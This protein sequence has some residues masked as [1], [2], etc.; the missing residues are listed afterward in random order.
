MPQ[1]TLTLTLRLYDP[2]EKKDSAKSTS[3]A[4][5]QVDRADLQMDQG[6]FIEKYLRPNL[7][8]LKQL[9]LTSL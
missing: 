5:V 6:Y 8:Q 9:E 2:N 1:D 3:W 4:V 7:V